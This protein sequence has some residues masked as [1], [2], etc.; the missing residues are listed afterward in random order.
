MV[1][2]FHNN[3]VEALCP[4]RI[5]VCLIG[6]KCDFQLF[7]IPLIQIERLACS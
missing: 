7:D 1:F 3:F 5:N 6:M 2:T 4:L